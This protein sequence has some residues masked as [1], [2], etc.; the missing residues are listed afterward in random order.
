[1]RTEFRSE[2]LLEKKTALRLRRRGEDNI[3]MDPRE[4]CC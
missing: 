4:L 1:M 2:S 3:K